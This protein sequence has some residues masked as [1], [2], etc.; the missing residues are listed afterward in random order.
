MLRVT[1]TPEQ[2][3]LL[4]LRQTRAYYGGLRDGVRRFSIWNNYEQTVGAG[5]TLLKDALAAIDR[6][7]AEVLE[8]FQ[9][10]LSDWD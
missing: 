4:Q 6:E 2:D 9:K 7:E 3:Q 5:G 10:L 8:R 1:L